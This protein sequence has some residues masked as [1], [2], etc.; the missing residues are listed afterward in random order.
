MNKKLFVSL[1]VLFAIAVSTSAVSAGLFDSVTENSD[2]NVTDLEVSSQGYSTYEIT[3]KL[4]P[5]KS[6]DYLEMYAVFY[7]SDGAVIEKSPLVWN[8][9]NPAE[10]QLIKVTGT[11]YVNSNEKPVRAEIF[12]SDSAFNN[13]IEDAIFA[14]NV[15]M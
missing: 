5:K 10:N 2:L 3:C 1:L 11:A 7:D 12:I 14:Q 9:N 8:T 6:F 4:T 13:Q 15:T